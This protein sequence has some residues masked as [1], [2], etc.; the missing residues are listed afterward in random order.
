MGNC[1]VEIFLGVP[2]IPVLAFFVAA[3]GVAKQGAMKIYVQQQLEYGKLW[4]LVEFSQV[5]D[6]AATL[7]DQSWHPPDCDCL[8]SVQLA[9][10]WRHSTSQERDRGYCFPGFC[11]D[12][13]ML[14]AETR[15]PCLKDDGPMILG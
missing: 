9:P 13:A 5:M 14:C 10:A 3:A 1:L 6:A 8:L 2:Q 12:P 4:K 15:G 11:C 7:C